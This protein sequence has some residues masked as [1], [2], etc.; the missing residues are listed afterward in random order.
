MR[1]DEITV[2]WRHRQELGDIDDLAASLTEVGL[3]HPVVVTPEG[4]LIAGA[5]RLAAAKL[6]GW[7]A[8]VVD[9]DGIVRGDCRTWRSR[10]NCSR[11]TPSRSCKR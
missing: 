3:L 7:T 8:A 11:R 5:R 10:L 9:L 4:T 6:L 2:G 1:L